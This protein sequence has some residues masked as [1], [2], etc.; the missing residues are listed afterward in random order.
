MH[1]PEVTQY[2]KDEAAKLDVVSDEVDDV[3]VLKLKALKGD[4]DEESK[5]DAEK[6][7][8][9]F[10]RYEEACDRVKNFYAVSRFVV[11]R[12]ALICRSNTKSRPSS[13]TS[14]SESNFERPNVR[15]CPFGKPWRC[16]TPLSTSLTQTLRSVK[17]NIC[18]KPPRPFDVMANPT[19]CKSPD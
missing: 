14:T 17:S 16:S 18:S 7:K 1:A 10:R 5:F 15:P 2:M 4:Y 6:D 12:I 11:G 19:G 8:D 13:T 9:N 3:N